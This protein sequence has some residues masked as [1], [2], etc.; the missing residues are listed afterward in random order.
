[1]SS[2]YPRTHGEMNSSAPSSMWQYSLITEPGMANDHT[3]AT[4]SSAPSTLRTTARRRA[5]GPGASNS[6]VAPGPPGVLFARADRV[7][8]PVA[9]PA[10]GFVVVLIGRS[11]PSAR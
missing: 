8:P 10:G 11:P 1:M 2:E 5:A 4:T 7:A 6:T 3:L 9:S